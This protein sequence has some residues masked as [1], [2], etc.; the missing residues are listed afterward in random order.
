[1]SR[2]AHANTATPT[3]VS[4]L[5][6]PLPS[7]QWSTACCPFVQQLL[8]RQGSVSRALVWTA[9]AHCAIQLYVTCRI[10]NG[11]SSLTTCIVSASHI[12]LTLP[13]GLTWYMFALSKPGDKWVF[14]E[15]EC[16]G[17][18]SGGSVH[19]AVRFLFLPASPRCLCFCCNCQLRTYLN[20]L[21][22]FHG[23][24]CGSWSPASRSIG[25]LF[26]S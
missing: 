19:G 15:K 6:S 9:C 13:M 25:H 21:N 23:G 11:S 16:L 26:L 20:C 3:H 4:A 24:G 5:G 14:L 22:K 8:L 7:N 2:H 18:W 1:M 10:R 12:P 17:D